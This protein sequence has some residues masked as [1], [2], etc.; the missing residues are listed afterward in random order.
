MSASQKILARFSYQADAIPKGSRKARRI[1]LWAPAEFEIST[2]SAKDLQPDAFMIEP[3]LDDTGFAR[4]RPLSLSAYDDALWSPMK[5]LRFLGS[6]KAISHLEPISAESYIAQSI[7]AYDVIMVSDDPI[8]AA[9]DK[10]LSPDD[11]A[12]FPAPKTLREDEFD[13]KI[14]WNNRADALARHIEAARDVLFVGDAVYTRRPEPTWTVVPQPEWGHTEIGLTGLQVGIEASAQRFRIDRLDDAIEWQSS[15]HPQLPHCV[16]GTLVRAD[17]S[18]ARRNDLACAVRDLAPTALHGPITTVLPFLSDRGVAAW[19]D[20]V[21]TVRS[22]PVRTF[23]D[24]RI[25]LPVALLA[26]RLSTLVIELST[27]TIPTRHSKAVK[28]ALGHLHPLQARAEFEVARRP[29]PIVTA[30]EH[31]AIATLG[32]R[33]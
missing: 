17:F 27:P 15:Q 19:R 5:P 20:L 24:D 22:S 33:P 13:G 4:G 25:D 7:G 10:E 32:A 28:D 11:G 31:D 6:V 21:F 8:R 14:L 2:V 26:E 29:S 23:L 16:K 1:N 12:D 9:H 30:D 3:L 18:L